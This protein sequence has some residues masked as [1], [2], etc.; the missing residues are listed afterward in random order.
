MERPD[1]YPLR[2]AR[3]PAASSVRVSWG[4]GRVVSHDAETAPSRKPPNQVLDQLRRN[5]GLAVA[6]DAV[7][8]VAVDAG[9]HSKPVAAASY[10]KTWCRGIGRQSRLGCVLSGVRDAEIGQ[11]HAA[12]MRPVASQIS[13]LSPLH[14]RASS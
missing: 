2:S 13:A 12:I 14:E 5:L 11:C 3:A 4:S 10:V 1:Q 9:P 6:D 7:H 8:V